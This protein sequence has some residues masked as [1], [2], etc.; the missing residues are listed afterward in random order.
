LLVLPTGMTSALTRIIMQGPCRGTGI[1]RADGRVLGAALQ[2]QHGVRPPRLSARRRSPCPRDACLRTGAWLPASGPLLLER[3]GDGSKS[4]WARARTTARVSSVR[5]STSCDCPSDSASF[6]WREGCPATARA[7][8]YCPRRRF[9]RPH[10]A[11][12]VTRAARSG[13]GGDGDETGREVFSIR[14]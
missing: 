9:I 2:R 12:I 1:R 14:Q 3:P 7:E 6:C 8:R 5:G 4:A 13:E 11:P 10:E